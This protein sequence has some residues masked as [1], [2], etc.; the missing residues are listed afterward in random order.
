MGDTQEEENNA[1]D[2]ALLRHFNF[3]PGREQP[4]EL[5]NEADPFVLSREIITRFE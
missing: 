3:L 5:D 1:N 2:L 4:Q